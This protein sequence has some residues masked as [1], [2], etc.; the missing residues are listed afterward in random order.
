VQHQRP[1]LQK[2]DW[3]EEVAGDELSSLFCCIAND[4]TESARV[5]AVRIFL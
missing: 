5:F 1:R 4:I 2:L 3:S